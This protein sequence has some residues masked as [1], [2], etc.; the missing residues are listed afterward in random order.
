MA[1]CAPT[2]ETTT[3]AAAHGHGAAVIATVEGPLGGEEGAPARWGVRLVDGRRLVARGAVAR[4]R[5]GATVRLWGEFRHDPAWGLTL[6]VARAEPLGPDPLERARAFL[7]AGLVR[8]LGPRLA[9]RIRAHFGAAL[10]QALAEGPERLREVRGVGPRLAA[11]I[12]QAWRAHGRHEELLAL[13]QAH[14]IGRVRA[15]RILERYGEDALARIAQDPWRIARE[16]PGVGFRSADAL[17]R[18][19]GL[20]ADAEVRL[21]AGVEEV[22]RREAEEG[23]VATPVP[24]AAARVEALLTVERAVAERALALACAQG[25]AVRR[26]HG[27]RD[28]LLLPELDQAEAAVAAEID[29]LAPG[30]PPWAGRPLGSDPP[31]LCLSPSQQAALERL[32]AHRLAI[33]TGGPGTGKTTLVRALLARLEPLGLRIA[34]AA[35]TGRAARRLADSTGREATTLHRLL[36][37]EPGRGFRRHAH[38]RLG[39]DLLVVDEASMVDLPLMRALLEALPDEAA[40][41]LVGDVDQLPPVGPG[42]PFAQLV[43]CG[44]LPVARLEEIFR[45][46]A[47][48]DLVRAAHAVARGQAPRFSEASEGGEIFGIRIR[49][50]EDACE[51]L[52]ELITRRIPERFGLDPRHHIQVLVPV[53]RDPLGTR[54]LNRLLQQVL[55]PNPVAALEHRGYRFGVGDRVMQTEN[56]HEREVYNGDIGRV[57]AVDRQQRTLIVDMDGRRLSYSGEALDRLVPAWAIT[58][59]KAQGS[60][61]PAVVLVLAGCHGRMLERRL[62]YT[63]LT[64]AERLLVLLTEP[65]ALARAVRRTAGRR[66]SLLEP[67]LRGE[68]L[69]EPG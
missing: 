52:V 20:A 69:G 60:E 4:L 34:L 27:G 16:V 57:V 68:E 29:R 26:A 48:G 19:L 45:Q 49:S 54:R 40:L 9:A 47:G 8:G 31:A 38:H 58:V 32:L 25:R 46:D 14:G 1:A 35:P 30:A 43:A 3:T 5:P 12:I 37:A 11:R 55:N 56:D 65:G 23:H 22:L 39:L 59:H 64:R 17:A 41:V 66:R 2:T 28:W 53:H 15:A 7:D 67:R 21:V 18:E 42:E 6:E 51:K 33:L 36:E 10:P 63:A 24:L 13:L 50:P 61:Y 62:L 44:R